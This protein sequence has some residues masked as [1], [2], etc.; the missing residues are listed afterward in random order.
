MKNLVK[1]IYDKMI[2]CYERLLEL[3]DHLT[4]R[5]NLKKIRKAVK[6]LTISALLTGITLPAWMKMI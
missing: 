2:E 3:I 1:K 5:K 4:E 6:V